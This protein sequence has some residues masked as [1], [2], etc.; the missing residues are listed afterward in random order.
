MTDRLIAERQGPV[1][2]ITFSNPERHNAMNMEMWQALPQALS[3][4]EA[5][6]E[7][8][9]IVLRGAGDRS[10]IS[11]ADISEFEKHRS[12]SEAVA[13]YEDLA[14][15][16]MRA[17]QIVPK[18]TIAM[19][20]GYCIGGGL[21]LAVSCDL[22][23]A[24]E[25]STFAIPAARLGVG[26]RFDG[27]KRLRDLVGPAFAKEIFFTARRFQG[28]EALRMGLINRM[29]ADTDLEAVVG[30]ICASIAENAPLTVRSAKLMI[31]EL[32]KPSGEPNYELC[33]DLMKACFASEDYTEGRTAFMEKRKPVFRGR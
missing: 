19:I 20:R 21:G 3:S 22:R 14:T 4:F 25:G 15:S 31:E 12:S 5:D 18:P 17:L 26:Y 16:S 2:W 13:A 11:G 24:T 28:P 30:G 6:D 32:D 8:K 27:V 33:E 7:V 9:V 10:F 29:T 1:G 23:I